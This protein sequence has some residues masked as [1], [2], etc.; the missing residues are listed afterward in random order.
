MVTSPHMVSA[1]RALV[2]LLQI[3]NES[4]N[5]TISEENKRETVKHH[6][7]L[8]CHKSLSESMDSGSLKV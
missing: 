1:Y 4:D 7:L 6:S 2:N 8:E 5:C 3:F